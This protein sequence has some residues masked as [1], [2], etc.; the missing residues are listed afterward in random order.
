MPFYVD[1]RF[2]GTD[3]LVWTTEVRELTFPDRTT[4][5]RVAVTIEGCRFERP[6]LYLLELFCNNTWVCD[7]R[8]LLR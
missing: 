1:V 4:V 6:G 2:A 3:T 8:V 7:T 5:V